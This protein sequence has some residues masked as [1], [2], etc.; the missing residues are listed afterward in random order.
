MAVDGEYLDRISDM[1]DLCKDRRKP[2]FPEPL[3]PPW[4]VFD[5]P[6]WSQ[7]SM[8]WRMGDGE[9]YLDIFYDWLNTLSPQQFFDYIQTI[10]DKWGIEEEHIEAFKTQIEFTSSEYDP[11]RERQWLEEYSQLK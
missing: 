6:K 1:I 10:D 9:W 2:S 3:R 8:G 4:D 5:D 7:F 11:V